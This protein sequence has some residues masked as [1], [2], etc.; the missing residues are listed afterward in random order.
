MT[1]WIESSGVLR[2]SFDEGLTRIALD[3]DPG[4]VDVARALVPRY[5]PLA[6]QRFA[7][8][9][10]V[11]RESAHVPGWQ[12]CDGREVPFLYC[13]EV[14]PGEVYYWLRA[15]SPELRKLRASLG[16][17]Q[18]DWYTYPPDLEDCFHITV[19]NV[20]KGR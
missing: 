4:I 19:G 9:I 8:H 1:Q 20:G 15:E 16:L 10:S 11:V 13:P 14:V 12:A 18:M 17:P 3:V 6:R 5:I 7:P 2:A